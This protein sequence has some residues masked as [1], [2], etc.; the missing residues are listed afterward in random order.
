[1]VAADYYSR[2][3]ALKDEIIER[4]RDLHQHPELSYQEFRTAG[5]VANELQSLGL[6]VQTGIAETGVIGLL[7]GAHDGPT[8]LIRA[9]MDALPIEEENTVEYASTTPGKMHACGHDGHTSI[10]LSVAKMLSEK[11]ANLHGRVK[12]V[13]QPAEEIGAGALRMVEEGVLEH[14]RP[15]VMLGLHLWNELPY[16]TVVTTP[17]PLMAASGQFQVTITGRGGHAA[18]PHATQDPI[19]AAGQI[20]NAIQTITSRNIDPLESAV[21][22]I[23]AVHGGD[24]FNI[25][26]SKVMIKGSIRSYAPEIQSLIHE[27]LKE[28]CTGIASSMRCEA[29]VNVFD[30][31]RTVVNSPEVAQRV[32]EAAEAFDEVDTILTD[33]RTMISEDVS[34]LMDGIPGC[35][36]FVGSANPAE[37]LDFP[38]HHPRFNIDERALVTATGLLAA[39]ASS[40]LD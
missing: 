2:A 39:A 5:I 18:A 28:I 8:V 37:G 7:N 16:G 32:K 26:P 35:Y 25:I 30:M 20:I 29:S 4:R 1:M 14:P 12:F 33:Y 10:A 38:H 40:Y 17:G 23:G 21:V 13:F 9:D 6:E 24:A 19:A 34:E 22:T 31:T 15:D 3:L 11:Q 27:R 36:F